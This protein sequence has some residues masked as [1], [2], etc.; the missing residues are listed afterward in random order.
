MSRETTHN[1]ILGEW[2]KFLAAVAA[3]P[4]LAALEPWRAKLSGLLARGVELS[5]QQA[6][7]TASKQ[8]KSKQIQALLA[9]GNRLV[10]SM[11]RIIADQYG[12]QAEKLAEFGIQPFRGRAFFTRR[13]KEK[14]AP[15]PESPGTPAPLET[16]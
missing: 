9:E 5:Q 10:T 3:N 2:Q 14:P 15:Q 7:L 1:G 6:A 11:R 4:D 8:E 13:K 16:V 12:I